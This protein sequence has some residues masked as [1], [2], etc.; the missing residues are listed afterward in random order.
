[1]FDPAKRVQLLF[2]LTFILFGQDTNSFKNVGYEV[3]FARD[4]CFMT[5]RDGAMLLSEADYFSQEPF[6]RE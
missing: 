5:L 4:E 1:M 2:L 6:F 3:K